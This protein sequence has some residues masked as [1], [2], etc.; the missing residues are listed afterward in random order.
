M[1][2]GASDP[3]ATGNDSTGSG[4][5]AVQTSTKAVPNELSEFVQDADSKSFVITYMRKIK[6]TAAFNLYEDAFPGC[7][8]IEEQD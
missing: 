3:E 2:R 5:D 4:T 6:K 8:V 1:T 7:R